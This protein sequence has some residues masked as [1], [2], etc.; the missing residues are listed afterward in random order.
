MTRPASLTGWAV[1]AAVL[2]G[3][4]LGLRLRRCFRH[5]LLFLGSRLGLGDLGNGRIHHAHHDGFRFLEFRAILGGHEDG[6]DHC[7]MKRQDRQASACAKSL[8]V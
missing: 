6:A 5:R 1:L 7:R 8:N 4:N 3:F 2:F